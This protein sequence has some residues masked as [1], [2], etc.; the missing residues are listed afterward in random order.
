[1]AS[2]GTHQFTIDLSRSRRLE[3]FLLS[4]ERRNPIHNINDY[5][6]RF[7]EQIAIT[8]VPGKVSIT[9]DSVMDSRLYGEKR[10]GIGRVL[11]PRILVR[12]LG[13]VRNGL[14]LFTRFENYLLKQRQY[15]RSYFV[16]ALLQN[17]RSEFLPFGLWE[18]EKDPLVIDAAIGYSLLSEFFPE[19][20]ILLPNEIGPEGIDWDLTD[21]A[22]LTPEQTDL[23]KNQSIDVSINMFSFMEMSGDAVKEYFSLFR[24]TL[25]S[26]GI[27][28][29]A[30]R[31]SKKLALDGTRS[32]FSGYPW[33]PEDEFLHDVTFDSMLR[34]IILAG[35]PYRECVVRLESGLGD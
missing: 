29:C 8:V 10:S 3:G 21:V 34:G 27:F 17:Y 9:N 23:I 32:D 2:R 12:I 18:D 35:R 7:R 6:K 1:M 33:L 24:R 5:W 25:K 16:N 31:L 4:N 20:K 30:N 14:S 13:W 28:Y 19:K 15:Q 26:D 11:S 22:I